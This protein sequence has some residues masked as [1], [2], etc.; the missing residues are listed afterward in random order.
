MINNSA[1]RF[2]ALGL[3]AAAASTLA[4]ANDAAIQK[5]RGITDGVQ[6]LA[7]YDAIALAAPA[8]GAKA[9]P[10]SPATASAPSS[11]SGA[12]NV[13]NAPSGKAAA[14]TAAATAPASQTSDIAEFGLTPKVRAAAVDKIS[15]RIKGKLES[16]KQGTRI[17]LDNGQLWV[18][19]DDSTGFCQCDSPAVE[20]SRA[21]F[22]TFFM[23]IEGKRAAP[24][25]KRIE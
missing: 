24:R 18:V 10:V 20:I 21:A 13:V 23:S 11:A 22:G 1:M 25:V 19:I 12:T 3:F 6:R 8:A 7:C 4:H 2:L 16:W 17:R 9:S 15:A 5:C 14:P